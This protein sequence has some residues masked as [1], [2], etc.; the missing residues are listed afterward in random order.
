FDWGKGKTR[1]RQPLANPYKL[2]GR[3]DVLVSTIVDVL[4]DRKLV[5]DE[6][7]SRFKD[8]IIISQPYVFAKG[9]VIAQG[10]LSRYAILQNSDTSW[11]RG[12][13]TFTIEIQSIDGVRNNVYINAKIEGR[14]GNGL[15]SEWTTVRSSGLAEDDL[16][17][18]IVEAVTGIS[19][20]PTQDTNN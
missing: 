20:E 10:E 13:M 16:M 15:T 7:A 11:T 3:R 4:K 5:V 12:Q 2:A 1:V 17:S 6:A 19:P 14:S 9:A 18:K 8:G